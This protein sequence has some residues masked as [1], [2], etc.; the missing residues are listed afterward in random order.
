M[1]KARAVGMFIRHR[2]F[3]GE[4]DMIAGF[5]GF[6][7]EELSTEGT[8]EHRRVTIPTPSA[9]LRAGSVADNATRAGRP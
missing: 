8:E 7:R 2:L 3:V 4:L 9:S 5:C 6:V 1:G